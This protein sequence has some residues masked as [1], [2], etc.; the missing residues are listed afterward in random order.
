MAFNQAVN[1]WHR[2]G[3][4][5]SIFRSVRELSSHVANGH[6]GESEA[7]EGEESYPAARPARDNAL[8]QFTNQAM[9]Q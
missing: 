1:V 7:R 3:T 8:A 4:C 5:G 6:N 2:C 9:A